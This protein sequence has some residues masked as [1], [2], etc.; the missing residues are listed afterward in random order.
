MLAVWWGLGGANHKGLFSACRHLHGCARAAGT[1]WT[2]VDI[3]PLVTP[4]F[5]RKGKGRLPGGADESST[6]QKGRTMAIGQ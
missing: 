4:W 2:E 5:F 3:F 1:A 6:S